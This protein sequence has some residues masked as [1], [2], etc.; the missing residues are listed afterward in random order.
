MREEMSGESIDMIY[1]D[2]PYN[3]SHRPLA[4]PNNKTGGAYYKINEEWDSF[5]ESG[6]AR[7]CEQWITQAHRVLKPSGSLFVA[8]S[9]HNIGEV[10]VCAKKLGLRQKNI[11][12]W[13]KPNAMPSI[14]KRLFTHTTEYTCWFVKGSGWTFNYNALKAMNPE[15]AKDGSDKQM[16]DFIELPLV[17]GKE[18][19]CAEDSRRALHPTQKPE[20]LLEVFITAAT[21]DGDIVLDPFM[22]S[23]TTAVVAERLRRQWIG[24]E[25]ND[26]YINAANERICKARQK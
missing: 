10:I 12:V 16:P 17:Q 15:K 6:Y 8:C 26:R 22:G 1:A 7:F 13:R 21:N 11:I 3:A 9:M 14:T 25:L 18:R 5:T 24:M 4:L 2:P 20:R 23:G 19:I